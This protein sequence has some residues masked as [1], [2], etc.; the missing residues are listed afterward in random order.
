[1]GRR[2]AEVAAALRGASR[3]VTADMAAAVAAGAHGII[4]ADDIAYRQSTYMAPQW[5]GRHL[6]P[7]WQDQVAAAR[8][9]G[10][11]VLFHSDGNL[12]RVLPYI[13]AAGFDGLCGLEP[14]AGM[15][16]REIRRGCARQLCLMGTL[17][18]G[19]LCGQ[20]GGPDADGGYDRLTR[21]LA[22]EMAAG[23][24]A[25]GVI[26]GTCS[27]LYAGMSPRRVQCMVDAFE[28]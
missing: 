22:D 19:L 3:Q 4:I 7:L 28:K 18:P 24:Q 17:D 26:F 23:R 1:M 20:P 21:A 6:L 27:G 2:P 8:D 14:A 5:L 16:V 13:V 9:S 12:N 15:D 25:G 10:V 11:P